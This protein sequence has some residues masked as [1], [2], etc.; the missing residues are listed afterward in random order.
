MAIEAEPR[1]VAPRSIDEP[2]APEA[3]LPTTDQATTADSLPPGWPGLTRPRPA[4]LA[5]GA[6]ALVAAATVSLLLPNEHAPA[7]PT[8]VPAAEAPA[9]ATETPIQFAS[10][11][12]ASPTPPA[13]EQAS[14]VPAA[15]DF[16]VPDFRMPSRP[17]PQPAGTPM[18]VRSLEVERG[19][20]LMGMLVSAG[21]DPADAHE[22]V[23]AL[24]SVYDPRD[25]K[26]GQEVT[27]TFA[28][29]DGSYD[30]L[31]LV[32]V[33]VKADV[34]RKVLASRMLSPGDGFSGQEQR[35]ELKLG[36][37]R[38]AGPIGESL[39][40]S[41][42]R[43]GLPSQVTAE[44][45][46]N[47][48]YDVDFQRDIQPGDSFEVFVER[49]FDGDGRAVKDGAVAYA[50]LTL[51]GVKHQLWRYQSKDGQVDFY[52]EKGDSVR[53]ALLKTPIDGARI[54]SGFGMRMHPI[55]GYSKMHKGLDFGAATGTPIMAA[56]DGTI[57]FAGGKGAYGNY[58]QIRHEGSYSTAYG[59][60]S[61][62]AVR[63]GQRVRQGQ[64]IGYVG[65]T[66]RATGPH[67]HYEVLVKNAQ[68]NPAG[69]KLP[70]G[71]KLE[72]MELASFQK[73]RRDLDGARAD[74][75]LQT[76]AAD[77]PR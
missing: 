67:L 69:L 73:A 61:R 38:F 68:V 23:Q 42:S 33:A 19:D 27:I 57:A 54:T 75:P 31:K 24:R 45:I 13:R 16:S 28:A 26:V 65:A 77:T 15:P 72:G 25:L 46:R 8:A 6:A 64:V 48:S 66:G 5:F 63:S 36:H 55:L 12:V 10:V 53:K 56:G 39:F 70:T 71:R 32:D 59:H 18:V 4:V 58:V 60:M 30:D 21:A 76:A 47:F 40:I 44:L 34:D 50:S 20:T 51:S 41:A 62:I 9:L 2:T 43:A 17:A 37:G 35:Q 3:N 22:A 29:E 14:A 1:G 11:Q 52:N 49:W 74:Q 7:L